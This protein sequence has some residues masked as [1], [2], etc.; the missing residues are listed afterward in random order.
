M[1]IG[2]CFSDPG[3]PKHKNWDWEKYNYFI[4]IFVLQ[5]YYPNL[6]IAKKRNE[7]KKGRANL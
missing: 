4:K 2:I 5:N 3:T 6:K 1:V 7:E